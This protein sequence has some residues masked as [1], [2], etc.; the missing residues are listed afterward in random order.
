[1]A[2]WNVAEVINIIDETP[3]VKRFF[4]QVKNVDFFDFKPGQF[5]TFDL[6]IGEKRLERWRS[7]SIASAP[8]QTNIFELCIV[9]KYDGRGTKYLFEDIS[10]GS[11]L[12]FKGPDGSFTIPQKYTENKLV[13]ICTGTGIAPFRS[14]IQW[15]KINNLDYQYIHLIFGARFISDI[16]YRKEFET[17]AI[18]N[19]NFKIDV[20]LSRDEWINTGYVHEI[21]LNDYKNNIENTKFYLCGWSQ[22]V[23]EAVIHLKKNLGCSD[24]QV[25]YELYG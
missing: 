15:L 5:V 8:N 1:M 24:H 22:M 19:P 4:L 7:Y 13:F 2:K 25:F 21:Y 3:F 14:M 11:T 12:N 16:L 23:D 17:L 6:P 18:E 10:V 20:V 9:K